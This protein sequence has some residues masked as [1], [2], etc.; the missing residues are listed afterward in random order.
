MGKRMRWLALVLGITLSA[1]AP[2]RAEETGQEE[3]RLEQI[4]INMPE[5]T[6]YGYGL[7]AAGQS[8]EAWLGE[9]QLRPVSSVPFGE[10]GEGIGY[11]ILLD[12][13]N[14]IPDAYFNRL[15][16]GIAGFWDGLSEKDSAALITFG[17]TVQVL[18]ED[19]DGNAVRESLSQVDN[20]DNRTM[21]FEA[22]SQAAALADRSGQEAC[23]RKAVIVISDGEDVA[24]GETM[25][26]EALDELKEKGIPVYAACIR[27]T[28]LDHINSFGEFARRSGGDIRVFE[29]EESETVLGEIREEL[30]EGDVM[31]FTASSN[32][33]SNEYETF[34]LRI[35]GKDAPLSREVLSCR[36]IP[37][38]SAPEISAAEKGNEREILVTFSEPVS[39]AEQPSAYRLTQAGEEISIQS[40]VR[41]GNGG[42]QVLLTAAAPLKRGKYTLS[43]PG[44]TDDSQEKNPVSGEFV[45]AVEKADPSSGAD[46]GSQAV[47]F[48]CL[49]VAAA[50][51]I[52]A[53]VVIRKGQKSKE[54]IVVDG[55]TITASSVNVKQHVATGQAE[56]KTFWMV[57]S[58][59]GRN[60]KK[61]E[62]SIDRS[63]IVGRSDMCDLYFDDGRMSRQHFALEWDGSDM[64]ITDLNT[65]NGTTVNGVKITGR[66]RLDQGD[67][68]C[69]GAE[70]MQITW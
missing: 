62:L 23:R 66:R 44:V 25:A 3:P 41:S 65:T 67:R 47:L 4:Y 54:V 14:S 43:C 59:E 9:E 46:T 33:I 30:M 13:S 24:V 21:L 32:R 50:V 51:A 27:D 69:A 45:F 17:E 53:A 2:V 57:I 38:Q 20:T 29:A 1:A 37:D 55:Q 58:V 7:E 10:T 28:A 22:V 15:K 42:N 8:P 39:G 52:A 26:Q 40:A 6:V 36:W 49:L 64:Y 48:G 60:P 19:A 63:M 11:Y 5:I 70:E 68:I 35:P 31:E 61:L 12:V 18:E 56:K 16:E 34:S